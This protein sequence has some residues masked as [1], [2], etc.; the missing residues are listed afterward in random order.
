MH[1]DECRE[2]VREAQSAPS[3]LNTQ[4]A[5]W[6]RKGDTILIGCDPAAMLKVSDPNGV[7]AGLACGAA[8]EA[9]VLALS[10]RRM[11][12]GFTELGAQD[13]RAT[14]PG[15]RLAARITLEAQTDPDPLAAQLPKRFTHRGPYQP[16]PVDLYGWTRRDAVLVTDA[17]R[18]GWLAEMYDR[19]MMAHLRRPEARREVLSWLRLSRRH[20]RGNYGGLDRAP[21]RRGPGVAAEARAVLGPMWRAADMMGLTD[22]LAAEAAQI[23]SAAVIALFHRPVADSPVAAGR[24]YLRLLLE[25]SKLGLAAWPMGVLTVDQAARAEISTTVGLDPERRL[26]QVVRLGPVGERP[27]TRAR[28][29]LDEVIV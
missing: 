15:L 28:R 11:G 7:A 14:L 22:H 26:M 29:P 16:G 10:A 3:A 23:R 5:R 25:A 24:P 8:A 18:R 1:N 20:P 13:D 27:E 19:I 17:A 9:T 12:A 4:P 21:M 2:I 6:R